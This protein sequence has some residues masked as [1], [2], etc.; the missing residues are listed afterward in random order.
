[1]SERTTNLAQLV[2]AVVAELGAG[3]SIVGEE[4]RDARKIQQGDVVLYFREEAYG[5]QKGRVEV[6]GSYWHLAEGVKGGYRSPRDYG[7]V[8]YDQREPSIGVAGTRGPAVIAKE[9][10]RR[11]LP[12]VERITAAMKVKV[13]E[14]LERQATSLLNAQRFA[15]LLGGEVRADQG[16]GSAREVPVYANSDGAYISAR[17]SESSIRFEH[18]TTDI[19]TALAIGKAIRAQQT[20]KTRRAILQAQSSPVQERLAV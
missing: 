1:M 4:D 7:V 13:A 19:D 15:A 20:T 5:S 12:E 9:I 18:F 6:A 17:V 10:Q 14:E 11:L 8:K 16:Y 2:A 3:W